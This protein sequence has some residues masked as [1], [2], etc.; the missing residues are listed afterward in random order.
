MGPGYE[1]ETELKPEIVRVGSLLV[2]LSCASYIGASK[3]TSL[4]NDELS[5]L[6]R[7]KLKTNGFRLNLHLVGMTLNNL[8]TFLFLIQ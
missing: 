8:V 6:G 1:T 2:F 5:S 7:T 3:P 4:K